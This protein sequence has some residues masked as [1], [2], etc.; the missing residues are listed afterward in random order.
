M[1]DEN[2]YHTG[3][4]YWKISDRRD[5]YRSLCD[6]ISGKTGEL[7]AMFPQ[8]AA[9]RTDPHDE[10]LFAG[11]YAP[12]LDQA[13]WRPIDTSRPFYR[14][15]YDDARGHPYVGNVWYRFPVEVPRAAR[16]GKVVLYVPLVMTEAWCWVNGKYAGHRP[17]K[18]AYIRPGPMEV[19]VTDAL[20][21]GQT[22]VVAFRVNT[23]LSPAQAA[24][25]VYCRPFLY[26]P[27]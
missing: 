2:G 5:F 6:K 1:P 12:D 20:L 25:G 24:E 9:F 17:Y 4:W 21:P 7:V 22:N 18:E 11:W 16:T 19:D 14:Q 15:G 3:V 8:E 27:K 13:G 23:S 10:G 26:T